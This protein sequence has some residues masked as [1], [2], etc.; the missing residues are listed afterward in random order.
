MIKGVAE[1]MVLALIVTSCLVKINMNYLT[2]SLLKYTSV[3]GVFLLGNVFIEILKF[4]VRIKSITETILYVT[5][6]SAPDIYICC[7]KQQSGKIIGRYNLH[8]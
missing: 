6:R 1:K 3:L 2:I 5:P 4:T 7:A 8:S